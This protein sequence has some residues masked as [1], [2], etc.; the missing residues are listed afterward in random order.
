MKKSGTGAFQVLR[1][2]E[3]DAKGTSGEQEKDDQVSP[4]VICA[5]VE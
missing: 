5:I 3:P 2:K 1:G 4:S